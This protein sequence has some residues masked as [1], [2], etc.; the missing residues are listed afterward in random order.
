[1]ATAEDVAMAYWLFKSEAEAWS[2]T[3]QVKAGKSGTDWTGVRNFAA[4]NNMRAM[5]VGDE[6][7]FYHSGV[8]REIVGIVRVVKAVHP[9]PTD[10]AWECV[11]LAAVEPL[12]KPVSLDQ[13]KADKDL[14][15][16]VL[17]RISRLSVQPVTASEWQRIRKLG[18]L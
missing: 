8:D 9:D 16:M 3:D 7:F 13:V 12:P 14:A 17:V 6:G 2:W 10:A 5:Q 1:M 4:R 18:G 11:S 15:G